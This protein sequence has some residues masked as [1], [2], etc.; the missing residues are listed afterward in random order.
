M[1]RILNIPGQFF[2]FQSHLVFVLIFLILPSSLKG[3]DKYFHLHH[4]SLEN[5][6]NARISSV[7]QDKSGIIWLATNQDIY[8]FNGHTFSHYPIR[9]REEGQLLPMPN[10]NHIFQDAGLNI[11]ICGNSSMAKLEGNGF[12][13][14]KL[15]EK[16]DFLNFPVPDADG[17]IWFSMYEADFKNSTLFC[18]DPEEKEFQVQAVR[19]PGKGE[20]SNGIY[21]IHIDRSGRFWWVY[22]NKLFGVSEETS[23]EID[24]P[25]PSHTIKGITEN[26]QGQFWIFTLMGA[27]FN[28]SPEDGLS[29]FSELSN[30]HGIRNSIHSITEDPNGGI[31]IIAYDKLHYYQKG[32]IPTVTFGPGKN[33]DYETQ[34]VPIAAMLH[35]QS[36]G[37]WTPLDNCLLKLTEKERFVAHF[38]PD[39]STLDRSITNVIFEISEDHD[40]NLWLGLPGYGTM[41]LNER[42]EEL[43]F[44]PQVMEVSGRS[45]EHHPSAI[46]EDSA[47]R[48]WIATFGQGI[49]TLDTLKKQLLPFPNQ[50]SPPNPVYREI[51]EDKKGNLW[52]IRQEGIDKIDPEGN[53]RFYDAPLEKAEQ[54]SNYHF[55]SLVEAGGRIWF[56][57]ASRKLYELK[58]ETEK[59]RQY[60]VPGAYSVLCLMRDKF[61]E[62]LWLGTHGN[63]ILSF[64]LKTRKF[65]EN[66]NPY[67]GLPSNIIYGMLQDNKGK[68][69]LSSTRGIIRV[70]P[71][72]GEI[73]TYNR[74]DGL[75]FEDF[76]TGAYLEDHKGAFHFGGTYGMISFHPDSL[77]KIKSQM[78]PSLK[79]VQLETAEKGEQKAHYLSHNI[80]AYPIHFQYPKNELY[81][82]FS[83]L[84]FSLPS[85]KKYQFIL[86]GYDADW[87]SPSGR[88]FAHYKNIP[89]GKYTFKVR[90]TNSDGEWSPREAVLPITV[91]R[92]WWRSL[93]FQI[94]A[95]SISLWLIATLIIRIIKRRNAQS[96]KKLQ[97]ENYKAQLLM[98]N[99]QMNP[100][101]TRNAL[102]GISRFIFEQ[103][104]HRAA[105]LLSKFARLNQILTQD[106][107]QVL[108]PLEKEYEFIELYLE[109]QKQRFGERLNASFTPLSPAHLFIPPMLIQP[110]IENT[111]THAFTNEIDRWKLSLDFSSY[112]EKL[113]CIIED[114]GIGRKK[115]ESLQK[116][117]KRKSVSIENIQNRLRLCRQIFAGEFKLEMVDLHGS[118]GSATGTRVILTLPLIEKKDVMKNIKTNTNL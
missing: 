109:M 108:I 27:I 10:I 33:N 87:S 45:V 15:P 76:S 19:L 69:W 29:P 4:Y 118:D 75:P 11:W 51:I 63:G 41:V 56:T 64:D 7:F 88:N 38:I 5:F 80:P 6:A 81:L 43:A 92:P 23:L 13:Q 71:E 70:T 53:M 22:K 97:E 12:T 35:D 90:G 24:L 26:R 47:N 37:H 61:G 2:R 44:Y 60:A 58:P 40:N 52:F 68:L 84:D 30:Y 102:N 57:G 78:K 94:P 48:L 25:S 100:H 20:I 32:N 107:S 106:F 98:L 113:Y 115:R 85:K 1:H 72:S 28:W 55:F 39:T 73:I 21:P 59:I 103:D 67:H 54:E 83:A 95:I 79:I 91:I 116:G 46:L 105:L 86:E 99:R 93:W 82:E 9:P 16:G 77:R 96:L 36:N 66:I 18:Y 31:W 34:G 89:Y 74:E 104:Y 112:R 50:P 49:F 42:R 114:N 117:E 65:V 62:R 17:K 101:F 8:S 14:L 3:Q 110:L 111:F